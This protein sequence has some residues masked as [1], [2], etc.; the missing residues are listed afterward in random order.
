MKTDGYSFMGRNAVRLKESTR[1]YA[2]ESM[3]GK[4]GTDALEN[5]PYVDIGYVEGFEQMTPAEKHDIAIRQIASK[6]PV[7]IVEGELIAGA[8]TLGDAI[9]ARVPAR[10]NGE[11]IMWSVSHLTLAFDKVLRVGVDGIERE[12]DDAIARDGE[13]AFAKSLKNTV[14]SMR[15]WHKRYLDAT[16]GRVRENLEQ[17]P[18]GVPKSFYQ[19]VQSIWFTF[20]FT[21]LCG[22]W[23]GIGRIDLM[24]GEYL[25][26]DLADGV[27]TLD[28]AREIL[29]HFW[30]KG[31]EWIEKDTPLATGDAQHY[32]NIVLAGVDSDG[33]E[34]TN[35]VTYL[36]LDIVE[37]LGIS[38]FPIS[39]RI[40]K[41]TDPNLIKRA[42]EVVKLGGGVI[43]FYNEDLILKSLTDYGYP[44]DVARRFAND[45]C[46]EVQ[47]PGETN[48]SYVPYDVLRI[49]L[50]KV[51]MIGNAEARKQF[52]TYEQ[53]Y[54]EY[55]RLVNAEAQRIM[56]E[57]RIYR[58]TTDPATG[59]KR[60][61][62]GAENSTDAVVSLFEDSCV[63]RLRS[64]SAGGTNYTVVSPHIGGAPDAANSL[65]AIKK[66]VYENKMLSLDEL[67]KILEDNWEGNEL[68]RQYVRNKL[69]Y[70]GNDNDEVDSI[71]G[72]ILDDFAD[73][74]LEYNRE[75]GDMVKFIPGVSTFGRQIDWAPYRRAT[76]F[77]YKAGELLA[78]NASPTPGTDI[79]GATGIIRSYCKADM[80]KQVCGAALDIVLNKLA[81]SGDEG[82][83]AIA[84]LVKGFCQL[85]GHFLQMDVQDES[86]LLDAREHPENYKT[87]S[88]RVSGWNAR[89]VTLEKRWQD[90]V[91]ERTKTGI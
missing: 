35:E 66:L 22:N 12:L 19:A 75:N 86:V 45:G 49:L 37:E 52:D 60:W 58:I 39:I 11:W 74:V 57:N 59:E 13:N 34:V 42:A 1:K 28:E 73:F 18:F 80:A 63:D 53:L 81:V 56:D 2:F 15:I 30:I 40:N 69:T 41:N 84:A 5:S 61:Q 38:D 9:R 78:G 46:W 90:M 68:L 21:R 6:A 23:P 27:I 55:I 89:F 29:A 85:D 91:I 82:V 43:A 17:V 31:C 33:D 51:L 79:S 26:K 7:R 47:I 54:A 65:Y 20:A 44:L 4:Y 24:L 67:C 87:L 77:G 10:Y 71:Y 72:A 83:N 50:D 3:H 36:V 88:V 14:E 48:F 70:Y 62:G 64:Y 16:E 8:A 25:K 76:P 32:Q